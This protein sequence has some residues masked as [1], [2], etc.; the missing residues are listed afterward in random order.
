MT[1]DY[2]AATGLQ[3]RALALYQDLGSR[4]GE[5]NA[6]RHL[7]RVR[8]ATGDYPAATGLHERALALYQDLGSRHGEANALQDLGRV[9]YAAGDYPAA[10]N[11]LERTLARF[12]I[13]LCMCKVKPRLSTA[14]A[15]SWPSPAEMH[16]P[17][18]ASP[19][20]PGQVYSPLD[21]ARA[22]E[23]AARCTA[24]AGDKA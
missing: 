4:Y 6:L 24:L 13:V 12:L 1:G 2:P 16:W 18:T 22:L 17:R 20:A 5:A 19:P 8:S 3:E 15:P 14:Q 10:A 21:E 9:R 23:G 7:G 11:L